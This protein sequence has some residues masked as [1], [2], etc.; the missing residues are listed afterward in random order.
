MHPLIP[1]WAACPSFKRIKPGDGNASV[2]SSFLRSHYSR[3]ELRSGAVASF[4]SHFWRKHFEQCAHSVS[5][6][7]L[8][9]RSEKQKNIW[10]FVWAALHL[11]MKEL[12]HTHLQYKP[13]GEMGQ[14]W[15]FSRTWKRKHGLYGLKKLYKIMFHLVKCGGFVT[16]LGAGGPAV[17]LC[18]S[19]Y[20]KLN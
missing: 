14:L 9:H 7:D 18:F 16:P 10:L 4:I 20:F 1:H 13:G 19:L 12:K 2:V 3:G 8:F 17:F 15:E 5:C 6:T 11:R